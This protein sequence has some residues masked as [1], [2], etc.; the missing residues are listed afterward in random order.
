MNVAFGA[1]LPAEEVVDCEALTLALPSATLPRLPRGEVVRAEVVAAA[2]AAERIVRDAERRAAELLTQAEAELASLRERVESEARAEAAA[3]FA[4]KSLAF[5]AIETAAD[6]RALGRSVE[7]ARLLAERLLGEALAL[8]P[9][10]VVALARTAVAEA[11]GARQVTLVA[12]PDDVALLEPALG[13]AGLRSVT[14]LVP[15]AERPRGSLRL[16]TEIGVLDAAI[17][18]QLDRLAARLRETLRHER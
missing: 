1:V 13:D 5:A 4:E 14:R 12:H 11:R 17:A 6:E 3:A 18:P 10:R 15:N 7:L 8:E 16:E 9:S 2:A